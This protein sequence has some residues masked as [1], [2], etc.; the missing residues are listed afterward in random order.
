MH[1]ERQRPAV[2]CIA[3]LVASCGIGCQSQ[4][5]IRGDRSSQEE[6]QKEHLRPQHPGQATTPPH[7]SAEP[8]PA[9]TS[10]GI[11]ASCSDTSSHSGDVAF[12]SGDTAGRA[13]ASLPGSK[14]SSSALIAK[15]GDP[16]TP[17]DDTSRPGPSNST[18]PSKPA[19]ADPQSP[20]SAGSTSRGAGAGSAG[21]SSPSAHAQGEPADPIHPSERPVSQPK[22]SAWFD[23]DGATRSDIVLPN[24]PKELNLDMSKLNGAQLPDADERRKV[25]GTWVQVGGDN[26][27][28]FGFGDFAEAFVVFR[29]D[30]VVEFIR[31]F[32]PDRT[33]RFNRQLKYTVDQGNIKFEE[34]TTKPQSFRAVSVPAADGKSTIKARPPVAS[35][36]ST[37]E[38]QSTAI[39]IRIGNRTFHRTKQ[40]A[41]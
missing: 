28:D 40:V 31:F 41:P 4:Q 25:V 10:A 35:L 12:G 5:S 34:N 21:S 38:Y 27:P 17:S 32:G 9:P 8:P 15:H 20:S 29:T 2:V 33:V 16:L 24:A 7:S 39:T 37:L 6:V 26:G 14:G 3:L 22:V 11:A 36:P 1:K 30:G 13:D 23:N 18:A 19:Q